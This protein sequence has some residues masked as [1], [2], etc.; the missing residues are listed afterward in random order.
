MD[1]FSSLDP[2]IVKW[3]VIPL[4]ICLARIMDVSIGTLRIVFVSKGEKTISPI[5]GF[6]EVLI[7]IVAMGQVMQNLS[8]PAAY[9]GW[10]VG[11]AIGNYAGVAI[12][13][14][15][16]LGQVVIRVISTEPAHELMDDLE[17]MNYRT[18]CINAESGEGPKNVLFSIVKRKNIPKILP[19]ITQRMP[20]AFY[21]IEGIQQFSDALP[22]TENTKRTWF[23]KLFPV[24][25]GK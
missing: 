16:A 23:R 6:F 11:F 10:A 17:K 18:V 4:L 8:S 21:T 1:I 2:E 24:M 3:V 15:L 9:I 14:K 7:W 5:L 12:E 22:A 19:L 13:Q 20:T 25:K